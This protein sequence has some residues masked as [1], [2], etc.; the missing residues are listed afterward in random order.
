[1]IEQDCGYVLTSDGGPLAA[2][3][4]SEAVILKGKLDFGSAA[5]VFDFDPLPLGL[6]GS[7]LL[8]MEGTSM[9]KIPAI[10]GPH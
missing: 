8:K 5:L 3:S 4:S 7:R 1:M 2:S 10:S 6:T 9:K